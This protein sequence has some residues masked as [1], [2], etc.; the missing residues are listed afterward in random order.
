MRVISLGGANVQKFRHS[1]ALWNPKIL[2]VQTVAE[3]F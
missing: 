2:R 3:Q 1:G